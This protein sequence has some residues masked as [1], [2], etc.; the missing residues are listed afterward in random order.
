MSTRKAVP[1]F[2]RKQRVHENLA[3]NVEIGYNKFH[4]SLL[5]C[6]VQLPEKVLKGEKPYKSH[7]IHAIAVA[8]PR[9]VTHVPM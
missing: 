9:C 3:I 5:E 1:F 7:E 2:S 8:A 6:V 4:E